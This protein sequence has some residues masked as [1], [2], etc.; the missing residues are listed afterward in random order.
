MNEKLFQKA[1]EKG[2]SAYALAKNT[3]TPYTTI[4]RL[5]NQKLD[6][7]KCAAETVAKIAKEL[8]VPVEDLL[9]PLVDPDEMRIPVKGF[10]KKEAEIVV[11]EG[12]YYLDFNLQEGKALR[13]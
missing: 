9:N 1:T 4:S 13:S 8:G 5:K 12:A 3:G 2:I 10:K 7:N 6:I 11:R